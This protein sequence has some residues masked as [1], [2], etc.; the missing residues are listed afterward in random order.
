MSQSEPRNPFYLL[1]LL[2]SLLFV[3]TALA[4]AVVPTLE[5]K[6]A[7][8]GRPPPASPVRTHLRAHG[9]KWLLAE[10]AA[11]GLFSLASMGLDR[12]RS[13]QKPPDRDTMPSTDIPSTSR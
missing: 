2:A 12:R 4:Y 6:A 1:L 11:I 9:G 10:V 13:L 5:D 8:I 3:V 7:A